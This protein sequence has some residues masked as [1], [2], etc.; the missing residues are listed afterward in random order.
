MRR[1]III[2]TDTHLNLSIPQDYVGKPIE[3]TFL[4][5]EEIES[6]STKKT[7]DNFWG[8]LSDQT[9]EALHQQVENSRDQ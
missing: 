1:T 3:I 8:V 7:M 2:P 5:L 4:P 6:T 9:A